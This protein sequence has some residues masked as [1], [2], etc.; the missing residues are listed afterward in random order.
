[1][2]SVIEDF[3]ITYVVVAFG[4][5]R[6]EPLVDI[7]RTCDR[8]DV[9]VLI[10]P[11]LFELHNATRD[12]DDVWGIPLVRVRRAAFRSPAWRIKRVID[13]LASGAALFLLAPVLAA[14]AL[15][16]RYEGGPTWCSGRPGWAWTSAPSSCSSSARCVPRRTPSR[17]RSGTSSTTPDSGRSAGSCARPRWTSCR[18]CGTSCVAT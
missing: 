8:L 13:V 6:E 11:R 17:R 4:G 3:D 15:A 1:V 7:L 16:V 9:E 2:A 12:S 10:V 14:I 18:S 5:L